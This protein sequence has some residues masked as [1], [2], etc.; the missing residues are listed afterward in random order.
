MMPNSKTSV[1]EVE[2]F[3]NVKHLD[4]VKLCLMYYLFH[5]KTTIIVLNLWNIEKDQRPL[6]IS[7]N[8]LFL[9]TVDI[10]WIE[11]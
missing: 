1:T 5:Y 10:S 7:V 9:S 11:T 2:F 4:L 6:S 3:F 8:T